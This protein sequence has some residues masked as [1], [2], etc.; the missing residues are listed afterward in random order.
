MNVVALWKEK[1]KRKGLFKK[2]DGMKHQAWAE[3]SFVCKV[4][5][6]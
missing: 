3:I 1:E 5:C 6:F 2:C 4:T